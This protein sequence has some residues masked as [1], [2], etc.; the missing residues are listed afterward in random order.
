[1]TTFKKLSRSRVNGFL[2]AQGREI[3]NGKGEPIVLSGWGLGN[4]LLCEGYMW[5]AGPRADRPRRIEEVVRELAGS[6]YAAGFWPRF[7][8]NYIRR[9]DILRM[10]ELGYNSVR[11]PIGWRVLMEDEPGVHWKEEGFQLIDRL[12][13]WCQEAGIYVFLDLHGAPG[14]QTGANIDDCVDDFPR[15]FTDQDSWDKAIALWGELARR[16][17]DRWIVGGYDLLNEPLRPDDG[18]KPCQY[19][20]PRLR[21]FYVE[22]IREI[23][24]HDSVH[25]LSIEGGSWA[26]DPAVFCQDYDENMVIHF[27]RY[28]VMPD[29]GAYRAFLELSQRWNKPLWLGESGENTPEWFAAL[30]PLGAKLG[31]GYNVWPWKKMACVN[32]PYSVKAPKNWEKFTAYTSGGQRLSYQEAQA[33][34]DEYLENMRLE[35]CVE[36]PDV[37][38]SVRREPGCSLRATDFDP[39][40]YSGRCA[41]DSLSGYRQGTGMRILEPEILPEKRFGFDCCWDSFQLALSAGEY[42]EYTLYNAQPGSTVQVGVTAGTV[43][44]FQDGTC[45]GEAGESSPAFALA[46]AEETVIRIVG[47]CGEAIL[48]NLLYR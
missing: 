44:A 20:L 23:R 47:K 48:T 29:I 21:D 43:E 2:R 17:K 22:A 11:L 10:G 32:S 39:D 14:G 15:L 7:R 46:P 25:M 13:D 37:S 3:H 27:H 5:K 16:Y 19:L 26:T 36:N 4:W 41:Q 24:R 18:R 12:L 40:G 45:L 42:A 33:M 34:F 1:M 6:E 28:G 30:Y 31:V 38:A 8:E 35:N 9:E